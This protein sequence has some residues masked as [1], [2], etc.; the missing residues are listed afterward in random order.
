VIP[1]QDQ[2]YGERSGRIRDPFGHVWVLSSHVEDVPL[3]ELQARYAALVEESM[4]GRTQEDS[5]DQGR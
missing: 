2:F 1:V 5:H 4:S 3:E